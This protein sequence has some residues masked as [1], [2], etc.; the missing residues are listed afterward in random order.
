MAKT[1]AFA[2][3]KGGTGKTTTVANTAAGL[4]AKGYKVLAVD[5]DQQA[6]L[7]KTYFCDL[8]TQSMYDSL[9]DES[10]PLPTVRVRDNL[11][12]V[13]ASSRMFGIGIK[14]I[15]DNTRTRTSGQE[16]L[17]YRWVLNR[18]LTP[19]AQR[20][21]YVLVDCPP[22][23]NIMTYNALFAADEIVIV[24]NP[25]P[26]CVDAVRNFCEIIRTVRRSGHQL[27]FPV[28]G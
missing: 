25:E 5:T 28:L 11:D 18:L 12:I 15:E 16:A 24:A 7:T 17:D 4:A 27:Y 19:I 22:S 2:V 3:D 8:P 1:I 20:Y 9:L 23:D 13:P 10:V 26:Y 21:D 6:N 14:M